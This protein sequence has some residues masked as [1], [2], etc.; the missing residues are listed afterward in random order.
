MYQELQR[1]KKEL[2]LNRPYDLNTAVALRELDQ[3]D[4]ICNAMI[5]DGSEY[6]RDEIR[7]IIEGNIPKTASVKDC[8]FVKN[9]VEL[10]DAIQDSIS[11][12]SNL[13]IGRAHV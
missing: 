13:E 11:I 1:K 12:K 7:G 4:H 5:L 8:L 10:I 3:L 6:S 9:Y 2:Q